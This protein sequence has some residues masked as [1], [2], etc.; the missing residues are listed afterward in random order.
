MHNPSILVVDDS[1]SARYLVRELLRPMD[2]DIEEAENGRAG[3]DRMANKLFDLV[4]T[5]VDMP[6]MT[7]LEFCHTFKNIAACRSVPVIMISNLGSEQDVSRGYEE[8]VE[9]YIQKDK[10]KAKLLR[11]ARGVLSKAMFR[12][13]RVVLVV[14]HSVSVLLMLENGLASAGFKVVTAEN[15]TAALAKMEDN[16]PDLVLSELEMPE[17]NGIELCRAIKSDERFS[18]IPFVVMSTRE[19]RGQMKEIIHRGAAT[20]IIKPFNLDQLVILVEKLLSDHV[21]LLLKDRERLELER[22]LMLGGIT[23][24]I[25]ALEARD[26]Y[27]RGHSEAVARIL[28]Q[29]VALTGAGEE[30]IEM[31]HTAG[32]LHDIGKIGVPDSILLKPGRLTGAEF[33]NIKNHP[34]IGMDILKSI[35]SLSEI[36]PVVHLHHE[37]WDG[38]GYPLGLKGE[39][40]PLWV[41][42]TSVADTYHALTSDRPY[43]SGMPEEKALEIIRSER[44]RQFCPE[45]VDLFFTWHAHGGNGADVKAPDMPGGRGT[46]AGGS[47]WNARGNRLI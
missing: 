42:F 17:M 1:P 15:G 46:A 36:I 47:V 20:Y 43:R 33:E 39:E 9:A 19:E 31:A 8:G 27:T 16:P 21:A 2:A 28:S 22:N 29:M 44:E 18:A 3:L 14:D 34:T 13:N 26:V 37:R 38:G 35:P 5:D 30:A 24:L 11:T 45:A 10:L 7:G 25:S 40:I 23:S 32:R 4:I 41:R 6:V 12:Q